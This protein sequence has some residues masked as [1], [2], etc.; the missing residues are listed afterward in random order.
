MTYLSHFDRCLVSFVRVYG[1]WPQNCVINAMYVHANVYLRYICVYIMWL[2]LDFG[3]GFIFKLGNFSLKAT[4][5]S[6]QCTHTHTCTFA[7]TCYHCQNWLH[8]PYSGGEPAGGNKTGGPV[9]SR[10]T[11]LISLLAWPPQCSRGTHLWVCKT[12]EMR[13]VRY[14]LEWQHHSI[15][16]GLLAI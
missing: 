7:C 5:P 16:P 6:T 1:G 8:G 11:S 13:E 3:F 4:S 15:C 9:G 10:D 14:G 2:D 12:H